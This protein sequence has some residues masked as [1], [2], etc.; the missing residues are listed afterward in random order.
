M[1]CQPVPH[2]SL[3]Y[4]AVPRL[5]VP[6]QPRR[7]A[8]QTATSRRAEPCLPVPAPPRRTMPSLTSPYLACHALPIQ[9]A[10][11]RTLPSLPNRTSPFPT[12]PALPGLAVPCPTIP[13]RA[14]QDVPRHTQPSLPCRDVNPVRAPPDCITTLQMS[15]GHLGQFRSDRTRRLFL[16]AIRRYLRRNRRDQLG[17]ERHPAEAVPSQPQVLVCKSI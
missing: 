11:R 4:P 1:A 9:V 17:Q 13:S 16:A 12:T 8:T 15:L 6:A 5:A 2:L 3:P 10:P 7:S 14:C